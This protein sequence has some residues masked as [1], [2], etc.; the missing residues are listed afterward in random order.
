MISMMGKFLHTGEVQGSIPCAPTRTFWGT[1]PSMEHHYLTVS[2]RRF[3][4]NY[5]QPGKLNTNSMMLPIRPRGRSTHERI[6][7]SWSD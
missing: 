7:R 2:L 6:I 5:E 1:M 4:A 3:Q